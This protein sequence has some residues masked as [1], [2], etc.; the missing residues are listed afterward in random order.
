MGTYD[1]GVLEAA[2]TIRP[3]L[4]DLVGPD[5]AGPLDRQIADHLNSSAGRVQTSSQ[6]Q[7]VLDEHE[8]TRWFLAETLA[9]APHYRPPYLQPPYVPRGAGGMAS[10]AGD[11][12][13]IGAN[14]YTCPRGGDYI[15]YQPEI[16]TPVPDCP[17]HQVPLARS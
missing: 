3:Y 12:G 8:D 11:A 5:A 15:W 10:P 4:T 6:L 16:G 7:M 1:D 13:L 9:D 17:T 2:R 14:R